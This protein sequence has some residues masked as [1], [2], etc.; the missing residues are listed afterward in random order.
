VQISG[1]TG[2]VA[3]IG[4]MQF[5]LTE[6]DAT[7]EQPTGR[8]VSFSNSFVFVSPA[9]G[10]FKRIHDSSGGQHRVELEIARSLA[11]LTG[12]ALAQD[13]TKPR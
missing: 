11:G 3:E 9:T 5:Q 4:L 12:P 13:A 6:L 8:V 7:S 10:L 1:V 2:E